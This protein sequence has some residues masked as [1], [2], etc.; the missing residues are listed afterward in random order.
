[1]EAIEIAAE[2]RLDQLIYRGEKPRSTFELHVPFHRKA[3]LDIEKTTRNEIPGPTKVR[4][5]IKSIQD[6]F[7][8]VPLATIRSQENLKTNLDSACE[9]FYTNNTS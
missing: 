3:Y 1:M 5:L 9:K 4:K 7:L 8:K 2:K 6:D